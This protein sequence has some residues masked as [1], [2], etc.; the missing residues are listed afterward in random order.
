M[1]TTRE[2]GPMP[3][4]GGHLI[5]QGGQNRIELFL[6]RSMGTWFEELKH[7]FQVRKLRSSGATD[8]EIDAMRPKSR[9]QQPDSWRRWGS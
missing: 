6:S 7:F 5:W 2:L 1:T 8:L 4:R 9:P 3:L